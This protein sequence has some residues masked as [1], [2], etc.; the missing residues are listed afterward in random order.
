MRKL[1]VLWLGLISGAFA[2]ESITIYRAPF[3]IISVFRPFL[4]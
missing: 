2:L 1:P 3:F 4:F